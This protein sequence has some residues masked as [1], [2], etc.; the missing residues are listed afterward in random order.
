MEKSEI[1][2]NSFADLRLALGYNS[3]RFFSGVSF[4]AQARNLKFEQ[5][6]FTSTNTTFKMVIG[7]RF[8]EFG[9]LK[10]RAWDL[11]PSKRNKTKKID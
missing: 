7:Y 2:L 4:I 8:K 5:L 9:I 3:D 6:E 11:L 1:T 10:Y